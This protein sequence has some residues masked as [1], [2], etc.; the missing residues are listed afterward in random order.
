[1]GE[2]RSCGS[3]GGE[4]DTDARFCRHCGAAQTADPPTQQSPPPGPP[5]A[6]QHTPP[7]PGASAADRVEQTAPGADDFAQALAAQLN[8][9]GITGAAIAGVATALITVI[10]GFLV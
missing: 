1:M 2:A 9:P 7:L 3:C 4:I 6:P 10:A 8:S 5:A